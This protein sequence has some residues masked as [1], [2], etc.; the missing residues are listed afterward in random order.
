MEKLKTIWF[1]LGSTVYCAQA[2][3]GEIPMLYQVEV[4]EIVPLGKTTW[5]IIEGM[6]AMQSQ[7]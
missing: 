5:E 7:N 3:T 2:P 4:S 6:A 1:R